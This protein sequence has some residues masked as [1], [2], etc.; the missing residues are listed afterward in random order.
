MIFGQPFLTQ[1][2]FHIDWVPIIG[3][4]HTGTPLLFDVGVFLLVGGITVKLIIVLARSTSG[5]PAFTAGETPYYA[6][7]LEEAIE[8]D[9]EENHDAD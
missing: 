1:Y 3:E 7:V 8:E 2:N 4:V 6:S 9:G 5:F